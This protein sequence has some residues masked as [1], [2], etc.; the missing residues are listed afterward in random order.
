MRCVWENVPDDKWKPLGCICS[1]LN[2]SFGVKTF[3]LS[4]PRWVLLFLKASEG[5]CFF[6]VLAPSS[7]KAQPSRSL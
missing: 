2:L 6:P 5:S 3:F 4:V 1:G 7:N